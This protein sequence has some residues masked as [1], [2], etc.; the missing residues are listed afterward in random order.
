MLITQKKNQYAI[1]AIFELAKHMG[2]GPRKISDIAKAQEIPVRFLEVILGQ[3]KGS[4]FVESKRGFYGGYTL[5]IPPNEITI[6]D[7]IRFMSGKDK[8]VDG[9]IDHSKDNFSLNVD[10]TFSSMM[11]RAREAVFDVYDQTT[12]QNLLDNEKDQQ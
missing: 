12:I 2:K 9:M 7:V 10:V 11:N 5:V 3:L 4:G 1:R 8:T 6:G